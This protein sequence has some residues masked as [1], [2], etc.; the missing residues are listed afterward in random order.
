M[1]SAHD[2]AAYILECQS[3]M[4]ALKL[5]KLVYYAQAWHL[6]WDERPLFDE[7]IEAWANG[8]AVRE[9]FDVHRGMFS[10]TAPWQRGSSSNLTNSERDTVGAIVASY[11][12]KTARELS[13]L[14]HSEDPWRQARSG[15]APTETSSAEISLD[16]MVSYYGAVDTDEKAQDVNDWMPEPVD[17]YEPF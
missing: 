5:Q 6:V 11:G 1:A 4:T 15:L 14:T 2:V 16:S 17:G 13:A 8:P 9:L 3:P 12:S 10:V 7:R